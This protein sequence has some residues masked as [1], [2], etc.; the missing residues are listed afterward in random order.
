MMLLAFGAGV[1]RTDAASVPEY[2]VR[3]LRILVPSTPGGSVDMLARTVG[4]H[5]TE[6]WG[7][8]VVI[9]NRGGAGGAIAGELLAR[10]P[11]DG[12][13]LMMGTIAAIATNVSL[14]KK[15]PYD[16]LR[17]FAPITLVA[18]QPLMLMVHPSVQARSVDE[19]IQLARTKPGQLTFA[20]AGNGTGGHLSA[21]LFR[22]LTG[23][24]IV[25]V[26]YKGISPA[27]TDTISGQV[28]MSFSSLISGAPHVKS[29]RLRALAVTGARR[30]VAFPELPTMAE[31]GVKGYVASTW[32]GLVAPAGTARPI[33]LHL[34]A[35][36]VS[37][38]KRPDVRERLLA[39][40]AEPVGNSPEAFA[41][42][43]KAEI[44]RWA[45]VIRAAGIRAD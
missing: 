3:P 17:D 41:V 39:D 11:A 31:A 45:R 18:E 21:E 16:P 1:P 9:D 36:V 37:L 33:V 25:H 22:M 23:I 12:Y 7:Q 27:L 29:G 35:E 34:N 43:I 26:P 32:Y 40:G 4:S 42:Y 15:L 5:F 10:A 14:V 38:L 8:P 2:P 20:S 19:L 28:T 44:E 24:D 6:R 30:A 13:T